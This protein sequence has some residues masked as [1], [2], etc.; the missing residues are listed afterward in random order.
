MDRLYRPALTALASIAVLLACASPQKLVDV[1]TSIL[2]HEIGLPEER[3]FDAITAV[4]LAEGLDVAVIDKDAG[5]L[6]AEPMAL[7]AADLD[8]Y[9]EV[10]LVYEESGNPVSTFAAYDKQLREDDKDGLVGSASMTFLVSAINWEESRI[11]LSSKNT[12]K[13]P[14]REVP[15]QSTGVL[16]S[17]FFDKIDRQLVKPRR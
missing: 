10:P 5:L 3:S 2:E 16:E 15:C 13:G 12:V 7:S 14:R 17:A 1:E 4:L 8:R 11:K 6:R 9:C